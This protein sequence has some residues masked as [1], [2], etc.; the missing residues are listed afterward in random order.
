[1]SGSD[2]EVRVIS[3][4]ENPKSLKEIRKI[5]PQAERQAAVD[6]RGSNPLHMR[7]VGLITHSTLDTLETGR[8]WHKEL[9]SSGA[10]GIQQT[11]RLLLSSGSDPILII[12]EDCKLSNSITSHIDALLKNQ[13]KFDVAVFGA[14]IIKT[15][16][17]TAVEYLPDGWVHGS[18]GTTFTLMHCVLYSPKGRRRLSE[19]YESPQEVQIDAYVSMLSNEGLLNVLLFPKNDLAWQKWHISTIQESPGSFGTCT[20]CGL[21][22]QKMAVTVDSLLIG[23]VILAIV[24]LVIMAKRGGQKGQ[25][26]K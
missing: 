16:I 20:L 17:E 2:L 9:S 23:G 10:V 22:P 11:N 6:L 25:S 4:A 26:S 18:K 13:L 19:Y 12:E 14:N 3:L 1:M 24:F 8:K 7:Q 21:N 15:G 5:F